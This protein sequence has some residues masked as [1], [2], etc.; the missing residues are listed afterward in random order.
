INSVLADE[1]EVAAQDARKEARGITDVEDRDEVDAKKP[2]PEIIIENLT[3]RDIYVEESE[4]ELDDYTEEESDDGSLSAFSDI[5]SSASA[6]NHV[7]PFTS[8]LSVVIVYSHQSAIMTVTMKGTTEVPGRGQG[9]AAG[10]QVTLAI[11]PDGT[12]EFESKLRVGPNPQFDDM[13]Q[14]K[15]AKNY[16][17]S[18]G[19]SF[20][21][22]YLK[23]PSYRLCIA[24]KSVPQTD[25]LATNG[26][27]CRLFACVHMERTILLGEGVIALATIN[28]RVPNPIT[29]KLYTKGTPASLIDEPEGSIY[30]TRTAS[31]LGTPATTTMA[32]R[33]FL[34]V[35]GQSQQMTSQPPS[36]RTR[37]TTY[38]ANGAN[39]E[40]EE[41][42]CRP[43]MQ[44]LNSELLF[45]ASYNPTTG[46]FETIIQKAHGF[47]VPGSANTKPTTYVHVELH[48][49]DNTTLAEC[50]TKPV[51]KLSDPS[52]DET[53]VFNITK[54]QLDT[55]SLTI[56]VFAKRTAGKK[57][58]IGQFVM[59]HQNSS[60]IEK[61][62]WEEIIG[63]RGQRVARW[64]K[65]YG[66]M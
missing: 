1:E 16:P 65:L 32:T 40:Q 6:L 27:R 55:V 31:D 10:Y 59:G 8:Y 5:P 66:V 34:P 21:Q 30:H 45:N 20:T 51:K 33:S 11:I 56:T 9:G 60:Q 24:V 4:G 36:P 41:E 58:K 14:T 25:Q 42:E 61:E 47:R 46:K 49:E 29:V 22:Q 62:H 28:P 7:R 37:R 17:A 35:P 43:W 23:K 19:Q 52:F 3:Y 12:E 54:T 44:A 15:L 53:F 18:D 57:V 48:K 26:L 64:H 38:G 13:W 2:P 63:A 50:K 39:S